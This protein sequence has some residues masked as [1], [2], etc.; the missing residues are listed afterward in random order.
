MTRGAERWL[1]VGAMPGATKARRMALLHAILPAVA[2]MSNIDYHAIPNAAH[3]GELAH[4]C[5]KLGLTGNAV[6]IGV[7]HGGFSRHN[8]LTWQGSKY[9]MIDAWTFRANDTVNGEISKD[10]NLDVGKKHDYDYS[11][12]VDTVRP[13]LQSRRAVVM[14][15][16]A[17]AAVHEFADEFF[18]WIY[19]DAGHEYANVMRDLRMWF[20]KLKRGGM[21]SGDDFADEADTFPNKT[22]HS[23]M[24]WGVK[25][26]VSQFSKAVGSP[27]FLTFADRDHRS[28]EKQPKSTLEWRDEG[29]L[30]Q[31][32]DQTVR[33]RGHHFYPAWYLF[34]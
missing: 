29:T 33:V 14:R 15:R 13:W 9:Y 18:D 17:E 11:I 25:S 7:W 6:E 20:P 28:T 10:K 32:S 2:S 34:K 22:S 8:L 30:F 31:R 4:V 12:A 16:Y 23:K 3:R 1:R 5:N 24:R 19:V 27:F 26:A 21:L